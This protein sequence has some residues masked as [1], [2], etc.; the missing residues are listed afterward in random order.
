[1]STSALTN[2][3]RWMEGVYWHQLWAKGQPRGPTVPLEAPGAMGVMERGLEKVWLTT[4]LFLM[5][6]EEDR[7]A[8]CRPGP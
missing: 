8:G 4:E 6:L 2:W 7:A 3:P 1:M 5:S